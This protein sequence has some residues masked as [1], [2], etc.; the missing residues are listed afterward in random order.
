M[1]RLGKNVA[2]QHRYDGQFAG[3]QAAEFGLASGGGT[4]RCTSAIASSKAMLEALDSELSRLQTAV[5]RLCATR[6]R[7]YPDIP[8]PMRRGYIQG[9]VSAGRRAMMASY[10]SRPMARASSASWTVGSS[11]SPG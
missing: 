3:G 4:W 7:A 11:G 10:T 2:I 9:R 1:R 8:D 6:R 5:E